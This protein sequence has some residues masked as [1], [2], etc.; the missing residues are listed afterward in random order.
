MNPVDFFFGFAIGGVVAL[1]VRRSILSR[2]IVG[3]EDILRRMAQRLDEN[4]VEAKEATMAKEATSK[5]V[6]AIAAKILKQKDLFG[7]DILALAASCLTQ[8]EAKAKKAAKGGG[9]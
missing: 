9:K 6:A 4:E 1:A 2:R 8:R 3:L 5:R 7:P